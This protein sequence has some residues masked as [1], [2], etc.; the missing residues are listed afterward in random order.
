MGDVGYGSCLGMSQREI[1]DLD[2]LHRDLDLYINS[3]RDL[4]Q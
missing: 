1:L 3:D 4:D 2:G